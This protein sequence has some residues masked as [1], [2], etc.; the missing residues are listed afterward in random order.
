MGSMVTDVGGGR[1]GESALRPARDPPPAGTVLWTAGVERR[2]WRRPSPAATGA[3][4]DGQGRIGRAGSS[5][6]R[7]PRGLRAG[8]VI[9][10]GQ[11][12][13]VCRGRRAGSGQLRRASI[14][15]RASRA[16]GSVPTKPFRYRDL[17]SAA[18]LSR[19]RA[20]VSVGRVHLS[21]FLAW[22]IWLFIHIGFL[23]GFRNRLGALVSWWPAFVRDVRRQRIYTTEQV[24]LVHSSYDVL[25]P[26]TAGTAL[27]G[28]TTGAELPG[29]GAK[30]TAAAPETVTGVRPAAPSALRPRRR[31][32]R[33]GG[34]RWMERVMRR[35]GRCS[36][37]S[38]RIPAAGKSR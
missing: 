7:P 11:A 34:S 4:R 28:G 15:V 1:A 36:C 23:T 33:T 30:P 20:V 29:A 21:G 26:S 17:G 2:R 6:S 12:P 27:P 35:V 25:P 32:P 31:A 37:P 13:R 19:G 5:P 38:A 10:P 9:E 24:G 22:V 3:K 14:R 16:P 18:Y 8:D